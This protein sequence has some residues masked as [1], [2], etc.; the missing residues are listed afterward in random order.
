MPLIQFVYASRPFGFDTAILSNILL[1][2]RRLNDRDNITGALIA[3]SDLYLQLLEGPR[4]KVEAAYERIRRDDRHV[5]VTPLLTRSIE[6]RLFPGW[7][8]R[9]DPAQSWVWSIEAVRDGAIER[10]TTE[11][12]LGFFT[13]LAEKGVVPPRGG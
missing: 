8:M 5:E 9:D 7:A 1:D 3:R 2:A 11:E 13:R 6:K 4:D 12:I 10:A